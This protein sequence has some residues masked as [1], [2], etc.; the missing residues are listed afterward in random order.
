M[1]Q[2]MLAAYSN[3]LQPALG[4]IAAW[5]VYDVLPRLQE[6]HAR[7][8][9]LEGT[10]DLI[11]KR[12]SA[13][14]EDISVALPEAHGM[15]SLTVNQMRLNCLSTALQKHK[16][17]VGCNDNKHASQPTR[18]PA[19]AFED[20]DEG[21]RYTV[22][23]KRI[24]ALEKMVQENRDSMEAH[25]PFVMVEESAETARN[26]TM[27]DAVQDPSLEFAT[28]SDASTSS[29]C[30]LTPASVSQRRKLARSADLR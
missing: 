9:A 25:Q 14:V 12:F 24:E 19:E 23:I 21:G 27:Q 22:L 20:T 18:E 26:Q 15:P 11:T 5:L 4:V 28:L 6:S 10:V 17:E 8:Q 7:S 29:T 30:T 2:T 3:D 13:F 16:E 1:F